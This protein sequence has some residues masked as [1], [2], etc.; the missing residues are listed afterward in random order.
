MLRGCAAVQ[1]SSVVTC[2][3]PPP[4]RPTLVSAHCPHTLRVHHHRN[5]PRPCDPAPHPP[6]VRHS[7]GRMGEGSSDTYPCSSLNVPHTGGAVQT[8]L[9]TSVVV[10]VTLP[11]ACISGAAVVSLR[12]LYDLRGA[13]A[14]LCTGVRGG[15]TRGGGGEALKC[16]AHPHR[17]PALTVP[18][19]LHRT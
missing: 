1:R 5:C 11:P 14:C 7:C 3:R 19:I 17:G 9:F 8:V 2:N 13:T 10:R 12:Y 16:T 4:I 6:S 18:H 15:C